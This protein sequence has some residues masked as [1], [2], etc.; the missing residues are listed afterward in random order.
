MQPEVQQEVREEVSQE[1]ETESAVV[2]PKKWGMSTPQGNQVLF[3]KAE[4][5]VNN[6][7]KI[8]DN[9]GRPI[10]YLPHFQKYFDSYESSIINN[11]SCSDAKETAVKEKVWAF[12]NEVAEAVDVSSA[13]IKD[14]WTTRRAKV[15]N[16]S[17][18]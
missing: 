17:Q 10:N 1:V 2:P 7:A 15:R 11:A 8:K 12:A 3:R 13:A 16:K 5:L 14:L 18:K 4:T 9:G 6:V